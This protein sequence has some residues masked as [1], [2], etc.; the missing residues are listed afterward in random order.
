MPSP[1]NI[2]QI[3]AL[4]V[5]IIDARTGLISR[6][7]YLFFFSLFNLVG[8]GGNALSLTDL[9]VG[10]AGHQ[11]F[12]ECIEKPEAERLEN[13]GAGICCSTATESE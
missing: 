12:I 7:W 11:R 8:A 1:L 5:P 13:A 9:Q 6:E 10:P 4:R 3:P 2:T